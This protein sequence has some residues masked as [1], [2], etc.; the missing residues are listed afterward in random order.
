[1]IIWGMILDFKG[2]NHLRDIVIRLKQ[3]KEVYEKIFEVLFWIAIMAL[4]TSII[5]I[6]PLNDLD[7]IRIIIFLKTY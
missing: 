2:V 1:M 4:I 7:E 6:K 3:S 5:L